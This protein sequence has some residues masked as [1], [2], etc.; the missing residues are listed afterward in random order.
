MDEIEALVRAIQDMRTDIAAHGKAIQAADPAAIYQAVG[1]ACHQATASAGAQVTNA[2]K[3][4]GLAEA[5][6]DLKNCARVAGEEIE[7][8]R[9]AVGQVRVLRAWNK[10]AVIGAVLLGLLAGLAWHPLLTV[11]GAP[12]P[13]AMLWSPKV[14][15]WAGGR[16]LE[17]SNHALGCW[18]GP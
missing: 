15:T 9:A 16:S 2:L 6:A 12:P 17:N 7:A 5:S 13:A 14:C 4:A 8:L 3:G 10:G 18:F 1:Q 11:L